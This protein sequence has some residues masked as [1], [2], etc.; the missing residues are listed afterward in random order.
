MPGETNNSPKFN[1]IGKDSSLPLPPGQYQIPLNSLFTSVFGIAGQFI[2]RYNVPPEERK[3]D[4]FYFE[5]GEVENEVTEGTVKSYL[6]TPINFPMKFVAG[7]YFVRDFSTGNIIKKEMD[8]Y[9]L[10]HA[11]VA[12]FSRS[13]RYTETYM[14]GQRGSVIEEYGFEPWD[15]RIQGF[16]LKNPND[17]SVEQQVTDMQK[18]ENLS[19][20]IQVSGRVF[21]WLGINEIAFTKVDFM[22]S[23]TLNLESVMPFEISAR[24]VEP[25]ELTPQSNPTL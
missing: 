22:P 20:A 25:I 21:Q 3:K 24:S 1:P 4:T 8:L 7:D 11:S 5:V 6:G 18:W 14:S 12:T 16:I 9:F 13:K 23:K 2:R 17:G 19:D 10:P 15:I